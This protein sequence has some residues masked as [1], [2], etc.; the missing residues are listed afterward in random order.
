VRPWSIDC[1]CFS[2]EGTILYSPI[3]KRS[4]GSLQ[5]LATWNVWNLR[6]VAGC[7]TL[8]IDDDQGEAML[9]EP[10]RCLLELLAR[11][12][13]W[14]SLRHR[15]CWHRKSVWRMKSGGPHDRR[16][17]HERTAPGYA[18]VRE[19]DG[20]STLFRGASCVAIFSGSI[21]SHSF[22]TTA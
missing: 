19:R 11:L 20:I 5:S 18:R 14:A 16:G 2:F 7:N 12:V 9:I 8:C 6:A 4:C 22:L 1:C 13:R 17:R 10:T 3:C 21:R 15:Y